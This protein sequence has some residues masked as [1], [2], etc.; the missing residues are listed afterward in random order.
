L[1]GFGDRVVLTKVDAV[2]LTNGW[3]KYQGEIENTMNTI[4]E[5]C[6]AVMIEAKGLPTRT[7]ISSK[8]GETSTLQT[9]SSALISIGVGLGAL[10]TEGLLEKWLWPTPRAEPSQQLIPSRTVNERGPMS[11]E[12]DPMLKFGASNY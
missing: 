5:A 12:E 11:S 2:E 10:Q 7:A 6:D 3:P 4:M 1:S 8:P 9:I